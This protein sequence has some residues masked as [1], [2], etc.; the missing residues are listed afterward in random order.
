MHPPRTQTTNIPPV[1]NHDIC[2]PLNYPP[3]FYYYTN[4]SFISLKA[5]T[6]EH[7]RQKIHDTVYT[8]LY[9]TLKIVERLTRD[10][11]YNTSKIDGHTSHSMHPHYHIPKRTRTHFHIMSWCFIPP[12]HTNKTP[13]LTQQ[14]PIQENTWIFNYDVTI[15]Y[16][17]HH[18]T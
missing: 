9:K 15:P 18:T 17:N 5:I 1:T 14:S 10:P 3:E 13:I 11:K 4:G 12:K 7:W 2:L 6:Q 8:T 16:T